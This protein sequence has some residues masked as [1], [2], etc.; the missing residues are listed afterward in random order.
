MHGLELSEH[1]EEAD[2]DVFGNHPASVNALRLVPRGPV[3]GLLNQVHELGMLPDCVRDGAGV[4][5][6]TDHLLQP[7]RQTRDTE[8]HDALQETDPS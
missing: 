4:S 7:R 3:D 8:T 2:R 6:V 1:L 5:I